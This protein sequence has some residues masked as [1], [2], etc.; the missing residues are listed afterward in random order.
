[1]VLMRLRL[2]FI[3][4]DVADRYGISTTT[5]SSIFTTWIKLLRKVLGHCMLA[6]LA[7]E[8]IRDRKNY[9]KPTLGY[10]VPHFLPSFLELAD[11]V[12]V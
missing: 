5:A 1:M 6:W 11:Y 9:H 12:R 10:T 8:S 2:V 4:E 3:N 7:R